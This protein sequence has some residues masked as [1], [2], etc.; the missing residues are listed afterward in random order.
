ME[1]PDTSTYMIAGFVVSFLTMGIYVLSLH[2][3]N[4]NLNQDVETLEAL[5]E[6]KK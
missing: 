6:K 3:R 2:L 4:R 1:T 5:D